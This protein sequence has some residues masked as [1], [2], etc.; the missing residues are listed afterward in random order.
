[1]QCEPPGHWE[2]GIL[3]RGTTGARALRQAHAWHV[4]GSEKAGE[5]KQSERAG[6]WWTRRCLRSGGAGSRR[7]EQQFGT[8]PKRDK[9]SWG[10]GG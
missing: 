9:A 8:H 7:G 4:E 2:K 1:M 5:L 6:Q 10:A 3:G